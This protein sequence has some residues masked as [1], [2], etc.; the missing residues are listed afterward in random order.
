[1]TNDEQIWNALR[2]VLD[3]EIGINVVDL[4]L[5][6]TVEVSNSRVRVAMTM[7]SQACP[8][9]AYLREAAETAIRQFAPDIGVVQVDMVWDPPWSPSM[10]SDAAKQR[11]GW[12]S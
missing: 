12:R 5:V 2:T 11:L 7:T 9:H 1:M 4:G 6:Y 3:P 8:L 10:M